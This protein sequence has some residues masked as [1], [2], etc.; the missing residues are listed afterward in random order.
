MWAMPKVAEVCATT[1]APHVVHIAIEELIESPA[2]LLN[3]FVLFP[4][5]GA[6]I[7]AAQTN[8]LNSVFFFDEGE[9]AQC[10]ARHS[11]NRQNQNKQQT[12]DFEPRFSERRP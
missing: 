9:S 11:E 7:P 4:R 2:K 12:E 5:R 8:E 6:R 10:P 3:L 1:K